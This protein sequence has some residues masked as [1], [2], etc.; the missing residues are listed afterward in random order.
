MRL[1]AYSCKIKAQSLAHKIYQK[2]LISERHRHRF[3]FNNKYK[4]LF[5]K[6]GMILSGI[7]S[8]RDLVEIIETRPT[9]KTKS[10]AVSKLLEK[11]KVI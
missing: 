4:T 9:S 1:G 10:W 3:E 7:C 8:D 11:V 2:Q 5:E 6:R